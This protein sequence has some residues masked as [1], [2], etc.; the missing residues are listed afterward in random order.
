LQTP[1]LVPGAVQVTGEEGASTYSIQIVVVEQ[2]C[3]VCAVVIQ[4]L[5][6]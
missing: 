6:T 2:V 4:V 1:V 5:D 3:P